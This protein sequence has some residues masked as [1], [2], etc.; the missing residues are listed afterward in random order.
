[1]NGGSIADDVSDFPRTYS[2]ASTWRIFFALGGVFFIGIAGMVAWSTLHPAP[3]SCN[4]PQ[5]STVADF[6]LGSLVLGLSLFGL[7]A[8]LLSIGARLILYADAIETQSPFLKKR[9]L[10]RNDIEG[11]RR[12]PSSPPS[13]K[14]IPIAGRGKPVSVSQIYRRDGT[15]DEWLKGIKDLDAADAESNLNDMFQSG[16]LGADREQGL[17]RLAQAQKTTRILGFV[18]M[19]IGFWLF[20]YPHPL[21]LALAANV[22]A[23]IIGLGIIVQTKGLYGID[24]Q[25]VNPQP[26]VAGFMIFPALMLAMYALRSYSI[27]D[28]TLSLQWALGGMIVL[29]LIIMKIDRTISSHPVKVIPIALVMAM[30]YAYGLSTIVNTTFD[31]SAP[32]SY[33][34]LV[35]EKHRTTGKSPAWKLTLSPWAGRSG[36]DEVRVSPSYWN[37]VRAGDVVTIELH[38]GALHMPWYHVVVPD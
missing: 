3:S 36:G 21:Y 9:R 35:S 17:L 11:M 22:L 8:I 6:M 31:Y 26:S 20:L 32:A 18:G 23:P 34:A 4:V 33:S 27:L 37:S 30:P 29:C 14:L 2:M 13:F 24:Q 7:Y 15:L 25:K 16:I 19:A 1:M 28:W 5:Q 12:L 10:L 38:Q